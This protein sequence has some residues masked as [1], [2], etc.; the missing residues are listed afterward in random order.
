MNPIDFSECGMLSF[1]YRSI[2]KNSY[3]LR[4]IESNFL[5]CSSIETVHSIDLKFCKYI[6]GRRPTYCTVFCEFRINSFFTAV[7][8]RIL[9]HYGL[10]SQTF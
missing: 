4:P 10:W 3:T 7:Q 9:A 5:K 6:I 8:K 1:F 2:K